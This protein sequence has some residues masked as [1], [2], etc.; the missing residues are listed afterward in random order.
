VTGPV[1]EIFWRGES[2]KYLKTG[3]PKAQAAVAQAA[4]SRVVHKYSGAPLR[5]APAGVL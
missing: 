4:V 5:W 2:V 3:A 1:I